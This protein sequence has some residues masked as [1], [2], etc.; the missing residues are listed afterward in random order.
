MNQK[1]EKYFYRKFHSIIKFLTKPKRK[2]I[3]SLLERVKIKNYPHKKVFT[4]HL[5][6]KEILI[7]DSYWYLP[8]LQEIWENQIYKF[9]ANNDSPFII[10]CGANIGLSVIYWKYLYPKSKIIAFEPDPEIFKLLQHNVEVFDFEDVDLRPYAV[11]SS[12]TKLIFQP[13]NSVG[14]RL[15]EEGNSP[16]LI[17]VKTY[18]LKDILNQNIDMLKIDIEGAETEVLLDCKEKLT[19]V[20]KVFVEYHGYAGKTQS[21]HEILDLLQNAGFRYH[22]KEANPIKHPFITSERGKFYD[23]QLNI[24]AFRN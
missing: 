18:R 9:N 7:S 23:L 16:K 17:D 12:Y 14:G 19:F 2:F 3:P 21:L 11:W 10:D 15:I 4:S 5:L 20:D 13:D 24:Y 8:T 22:I 6:N 1:I